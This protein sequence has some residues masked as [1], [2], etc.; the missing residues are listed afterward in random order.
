MLI[1]HFVNDPITS[2]YITIEGLNRRKRQIT[3]SYDS[4]K[5]FDKD[6]KSEHARHDEKYAKVKKRETA[7]GIVSYKIYNI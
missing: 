1:K 4:V 6:A 5:E 7:Q 2:K 3:S